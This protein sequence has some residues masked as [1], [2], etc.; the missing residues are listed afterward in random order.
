MFLFISTQD[1][2]DASTD[3]CEILHGDQ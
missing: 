2:R 3:Q 1:L